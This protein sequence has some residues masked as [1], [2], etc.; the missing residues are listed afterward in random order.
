MTV[1]AGIA[2]EMSAAG[3]RVTF[4]RFMQLALTHPVDGYYS[5]GEVRIGMRGDFSTAPRLSPEFCQS[6]TRLL[7]DLVEA[8]LR[9]TG[10]GRIA[11]VELGAGE[12]DL[13]TALLERWDA[14]R[15]ALRDRLGY[16]IVEASDPLRARQRRALSSAG[17]R[18]WRVCWAADVDEALASVEGGVVFG[19]EFLDALPVH[20]VDVGGDELLEAWVELDGEDAK[21]VWGGLSPEARDELQAAFDEVEPAKLKALTGDGIIELRPAARSLVERVAAGGSDVCLLTVDYGDWH[22]APGA[23]RAAAP[24]AGTREPYRRTLRGYLKHQPVDDLYSHVG[25]QDL[26]ADVDFRALDAHGRGVGLETV[27]YITLADML[28]ADDGV[29]KLTELR[30]QAAQAT[31]DALEADRRATVLEKLLDYEGLGAAFK[32]ML[33]VKGRGAS[34]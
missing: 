33:Q 15:P 21:E 31:E 10:T 30:R 24:G 9:E 3:G 12:G 4:A 13:A 18:G 17:E 32:V 1:P 7:G 19:N 16:T 6:M 14:E 5:R 20:V 28:R 26:T 22:I 23:R 29:Q 8:A 27:F 25:R 11:L 34:R 2:E